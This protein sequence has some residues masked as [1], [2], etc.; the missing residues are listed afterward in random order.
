[1]ESIKKVL[2]WLS[3]NW[4][5][6]VI[7]VGLVLEIARRIV[8]KTPTLKDDEAVKKAGS[9]WETIKFAADKYLVPESKK[10]TE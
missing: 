8:A 6:V 2:S 9:T 4:G 10:K 7:V 1:M 5:F 3:E